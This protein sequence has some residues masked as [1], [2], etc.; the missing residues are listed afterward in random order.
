MKLSHTIL[1]L[2]GIVWCRCCRQRR[3][4]VA[5]LVLTK[6]TSGFAEEPKVERGRQRD[7]EGEKG[8]KQERGIV[9]GAGASCVYL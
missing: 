5:A 4:I 9:L 1:V 3:L 6:L 7:S 2:C 8:E